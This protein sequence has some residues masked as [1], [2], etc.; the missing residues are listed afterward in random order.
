MLTV[1]ED[2]DDL[3]AAIKLGAQG[4]LLKNLESAQLRTMLQAVERGEPAITPAT[5]ARILAEFGQKD[6][7]RAEDPDRLTDRELDVLRLV[8]AGLRNKEIAARLGISENTVKF[9]LG[10]ILAKLHAQSRT[11]LAALAVRE[12]LLE[13]GRAADVL[14]GPGPLGPG[15][16]GT[17]GPTRP[18]GAVHHPDA[19]R[20]DA[21]PATDALLRDPSEEQRWAIASR[22]I[23]TNCI[24]C[25][26]CMDVCPV[27]ALDMSRPAG[28]G[29]EFGGAA[30]VP[31]DWMM[32]HPVQVGECIGCSICIRECPVVVMT[33]DSVEG[34][35]PLEALARAR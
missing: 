23:T 35:T 25:G 32:E 30:G 21:D 12:G 28:P 13:R 9:H 1:S 4:Y 22:S 2:E 15:R 14:T 16:G 7:A 6:R 3:F 8:T 34:E 31:F 19:C 27:Q 17:G 5:A 20:A 29:V 26:V 18:S 11:E 10:N 33:L 24:N